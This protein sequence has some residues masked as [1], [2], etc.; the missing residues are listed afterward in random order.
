ML[1]LKN[2]QTV[3]MCLEQANPPSF[4]PESSLSEFVARGSYSRWG[5]KAVLDSERVVRES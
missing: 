5:S 4:L 2:K 3:A 1:H